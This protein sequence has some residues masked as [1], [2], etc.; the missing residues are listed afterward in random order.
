MGSEGPQPSL[1]WG[2]DSAAPRLGARLALEGSCCF[3]GHL[4]TLVPHGLT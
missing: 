4:L 2:Q 1:Q 3:K